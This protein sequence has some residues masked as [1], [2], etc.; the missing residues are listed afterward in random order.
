LPDDLDCPESSDELYI[1]RGDEVE[2]WR[3]VMT[4]DVFRDLPVPGVEAS[5]FSMIVSH[6]CSM[7]RG[8]ALAERLQA[9]PVIEYQQ[10]SF[11]QWA[12]GFVRF[13]PLP[14]FPSS[15]AHHAVNLNEVGMVS[16]SA[17]MLDRRVACLSERAIAL[18]LQRT[19]KNQSRV[20][21]SLG[22]IEEA[23]GGMMEE[24][25]LWEEW[26]E[27][28]AGARVDN[29]ANLDATLEEEA[30]AFE[31]FL[32]SSAEGTTSSLRDRLKLVSERTAVRRAVRHEMRRR[33]GDLADR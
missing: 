26:N 31:G 1:A 5:P 33:L 11:N 4:G 8:A 9:M 23:F 7:R 10:V 32:A 14:D 21:V 13:L 29:G 3:P 27:E 28:I 25:A 2:A 12:Q 19:F 30:A 16:S 22:R 24:I 17:L 15:G 20:V 18:L 6:P